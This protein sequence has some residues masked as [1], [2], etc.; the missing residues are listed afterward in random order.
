MQAR[1]QKHS[2][3][4]AVN[5]RMQG[6]VFPPKDSE[7]FAIDW[8]CR[9]RRLRSYW[10][11]ANNQFGYGNRRELRLDPN[12]SRRLFNFEA[13]ESVKWPACLGTSAFHRGVPQRPRICTLLFCALCL[14]VAGRKRRNREIDRQQFRPSAV[15]QGCFFRNQAAF[16][17][18]LSKFNPSIRSMAA[19]SSAMCL[20]SSAR[21][22]ATSFI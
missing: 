9:R 3:P 7:P 15:C 12:P 6:V 20:F 14:R 22:A 21:L 17:N 4:Q 10:R 2:L 1:G 8:G 19:V 11:S 16:E 13:W 5:R 18:N